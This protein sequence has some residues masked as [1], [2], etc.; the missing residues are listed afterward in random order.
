MTNE[1][2]VWRFQDDISTDAIQPSRYMHLRSNLD[3][4]AT[5]VFEDINPGFAG[6]V[7]PGDFVV[8]GKNFGMGSSRE[9][10]PLLLKLLGV[11]AVIARSFARI[12]YRNAINLGLAAVMCD[13]A[14]IGEGEHLNLDLAEG[15]VRI[16]ESGVL[17]P[18]QPMPQ[19]MLNI[20]ADGGIVAHL[21]KH[22]GQ[23]QV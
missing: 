1:G 2:R 15:S 3:E 7:R 21:Q 16:V 11:R 20:L 10:A 14:A 23:V 8:A 13:T 17:I 6:S 5:H 19:V 9:H 4:L 18:V 12:F 22:G